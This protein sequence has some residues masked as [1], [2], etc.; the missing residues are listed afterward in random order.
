MRLLEQ[1]TMEIRRLSI[2]LELNHTVPLCLV[3][4]PGSGSGV[5]SVELKEPVSSVHLLMY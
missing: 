1:Q 2:A 3:Y 4:L 5:A